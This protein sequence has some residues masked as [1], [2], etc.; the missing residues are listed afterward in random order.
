M[1]NYLS[2]LGLPRKAAISEITHAISEAMKQ[3]DDVQ[4]LNDAELILSEKV[5]RTYY[6]RA[7]LQYEAINAALECLDAADAV[8]THRWAERLVEFDQ[9]QADPLG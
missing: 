8:D 5:T 1:K 4:S 7:H 3:T 6:E 9:E 2:R